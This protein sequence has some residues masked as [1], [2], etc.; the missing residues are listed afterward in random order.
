MVYLFI[1]EVAEACNP[2][3]V[4]IVTSSLT[5][6][7]NS[8]VDLY[9]GNS[10]RVLARIVDAAMLGAIER[11]VKQA[12]VDKSPIVAQSA[13]VSAQ[14]LF[15]QSAE[16]A[17][18]VRRWLNE[19]Q[20]TVNNNS[21]GCEM[22]QYHGLCLLYQIKMHDRLAVSKLVTQFS[23]PGSLKSH[24]AI[25]ALIRYTFQLMVDESRDNKGVSS[26]R[27][28]DV[29]KQ[30]YAF[31]EASLRHRNEM[32]VYEAAKSICALPGVELQDLNPAINVLQLFLSSSKSIT[33][34]A[35]MKTLSEVAAKAP[36]AIT[37]CNDEM[38]S[39]ISDSNRS[40]ATLAITT[41]LKTGSESSVDRLMKQISGFMNDIGDEFKIVV[42]NSIQELC[43]KYPG[44]HRIL[45]QFL[46]TFLR[47]E[48]GFDFKKAIVDSIVF[49][50]SNIPETKESGLLHLCEFI[51][52][53]EFTS[54]STSILHLI[55]S[56]GP[57]TTE[58]ARYIRFIYNRVIL[59]NAAVRASAVTALA[60]FGA[61]VPS[62]RTSVLVLLK[63]SLSDEDDEV[64]D[65]ASIAVTIL[66]KALE[67]N[68]YA[69]PVPKDEDDIVQPLPDVP[70]SDDSAAFLLLEPF[71]MSFSQLER[72]LKMYASTPG[73][74][75][76]SEELTLSAL[77]IVE[78]AFVEDVENNN[79]N[80][81]SSA[82]GSHSQST[83]EEQVEAALV[84]PAADVYAIPELA[85]LGRAFRSSSAV[86]LTESETEYVVKCVKHIFKDHV[87]LQF[88][89]Q[90]T[91]DSQRLDNVTVNV[92]GESDALGVTSEVACPQIKYGQ[93]G[94][95]FVVLERD[96]DVSIGPCV[97]SCELKFTVVGVDPNTGEEEGD[98]YDE[99]YPMEDLEVNTSDFMAKV[100]LGDFRR[101]WD[102]MGN[103]AE[104]LEKF[105]LQ[106]KKLDD[107]VVA[108]IDFFGMHPNDG[109]NVVK[110][111]AGG[112]PHM[113]HLSGVFVGSVPVM[114]R[115]QLTMSA[116]GAG[117][118]VLKIAVR[119]EDAA[120]SRQVADCIR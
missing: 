22:V 37:K 20:M 59:E 115:A 114:V 11:Y 62:L 21:N 78:V 45:I 64:R 27:G 28:S 53:C 119:S 17:S 89:C 117:G 83:A 67:E 88:S 55:G 63:R 6:D 80:K 98:S 111:V 107:A 54:L 79:N 82:T 86:P 52:D 95:T 90:N 25:I 104:V 99:D 5:K 34:Y 24:F 33:R 113:L 68:S 60:K 51:E 96:P 92:E 61:K 118:V 120:I 44:K 42:V 72:S 56:L 116:E 76:S 106:F 26:S 93:T 29:A 65:R 49:L 69:Q 94:N 13:L 8:D 18:I 71:P 50:M 112:K 66:A 85:A 14:H 102:T 40:I 101:S 84:D 38:E 23:K 41:L 100:S 32:I 110:N 74:L 9:R 10:I 77:P 15:L 3:D 35:A 12:I 108:V 97:F 103:D 73:A 70:T 75:T 46:S 19:I 30:G 91:I 4:I 1:K 16:N 58:P 2:D 109:T 81:S 31:L 43:M 7:M 57:M 47:E 87:V 39:L 36:M 105:A 48:G